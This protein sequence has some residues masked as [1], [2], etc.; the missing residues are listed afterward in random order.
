MFHTVQVLSTLNNVEPS[1]PAPAG[2]HGQH[3]A[4]HHLLDHPEHP[5]TETVCRRE[6]DHPA[7]VAGNADHVASQ[8]PNCPEMFNINYKEKY[9]RVSY[10]KIYLEISFADITTNFVYYLMLRI[11]LPPL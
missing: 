3:P 9:F 7:N 5:G 8:H 4:E 6:Q 10:R 11:L 2:H 1:R